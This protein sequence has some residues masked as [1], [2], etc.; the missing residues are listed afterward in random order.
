MEAAI[1]MI[2]EL[3]SGEIRELVRGKY[4]E[5]ALNSTSKYKFR[6]GKQYALDLGYAAGEIE[7]F[8]EMLAESFTGVSSYLARCGEF[9]P[10]EVILELGAGGG[11]DT[12]LLARKVGPSGKV[13]GIDLSLAMVRKAVTGLGRLGL[14]NV[15]CVQA[16][17]EELP[18]PDSSVD[19]V[20][21]NGIF[22]LSPEKERILEEVHRV[23]KP[24]G[25]VLCSEIVLQREPSLEER[26]HEE[27]W[28]K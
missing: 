8:P 21:S 16:L 20:V 23:L 26:F 19:W 24:R 7:S 12:A 22:N 5:V 15:R 14:P 27:D 10:G 3:S 1:K 28:F 11:L 4:S 18:L 6:V 2:G 25:R 9:A 17:A 13:I